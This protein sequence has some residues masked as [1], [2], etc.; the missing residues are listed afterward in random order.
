VNG[1]A[2][3]IDLVRTKFD[4]FPDGLIPQANFRLVCRSDLGPLNYR[5]K[6]KQPIELHLVTE[7]D[8]TS[9]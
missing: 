1:A 6:P 9:A 3:D 7:H 2:A 4:F 5:R 8:P